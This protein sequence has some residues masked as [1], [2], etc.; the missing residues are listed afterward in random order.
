MPSRTPT[1][2]V[3]A[4][5]NGAGKT[6]FAKEF[7]PKEVKCFRFLNADEMARGIS[8]LKPSAGA[9]R[10]GRLMLTEIGESLKRR[11][12]FGLESTLS[13]KTYIRLFREAR[14]LGYEIELHYL[15]LSSPAQAIE[16][17]RERVRMGGHHVPAVD[18]RRRFKRSL[19][20]LLGD[21]LPLAMRWAVWDSRELPVKQL[22]SSRGSDVESLRQLIGA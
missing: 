4:G 13:G 10:A 20:H 1:I 14:K 9:M 18:I 7:L 2:Y 8:P 15:W 11:E 6:T 12:T 22:A 19:T 16:R 5:C 17:V 21:Y 3:I